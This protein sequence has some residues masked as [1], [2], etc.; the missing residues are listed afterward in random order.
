[1]HIMEGFL[2]PLHAAA[3]G[4]GALPFVVIGIRKAG[5]LLREKPETRLL[6]GACAAFS[7]VLSALKLP[8]VTG[9]C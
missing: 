6:L 8:S 9:S 4:A 2:P 1:M 3:W 7:F 5:R